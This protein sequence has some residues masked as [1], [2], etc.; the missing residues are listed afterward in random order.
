MPELTNA[1]ILSKQPISAEAP[2]IIER[3]VV[4][5]NVPP[6]PADVLPNAEALDPSEELE[7]TAVPDN[8]LPA[9]EKRQKKTDGTGN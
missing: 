9:P 5:S 6:L 1:E 8:L 2:D 3:V 4:F 7:K